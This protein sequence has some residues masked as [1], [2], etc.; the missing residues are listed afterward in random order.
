MS[1]C[2]YVNQSFDSCVPSLKDQY[3]LG[4]TIYRLDDDRRG[5]NVYGHAVFTV[6]IKKNIRSTYNTLKQNITSISLLRRM[7]KK[8][9]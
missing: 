1:I 3:P 7:I 8:C 4:S 9:C 5:V 2:I 6:K